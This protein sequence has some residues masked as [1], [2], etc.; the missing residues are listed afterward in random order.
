[1]PSAPGGR[2]IQNHDGVLVNEDRHKLCRSGV[3]MLLCLVKHSR[4]DMSNGVREFS[5]ALIGPSEA[6]FKDMLE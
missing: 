2:V 5:K 1:M 6:A 4:P 3:G